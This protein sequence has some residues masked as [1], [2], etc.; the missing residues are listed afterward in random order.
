MELDTLNSRLLAELDNN[1]RQS[2]SKIAKKLRVGKNVINYRINNLEKAGIIQGYYTVIDAYRLGYSAY[3]IYLK[4][5]YTSPRKE[6]EIV[7]YLVKLPQTRWVVFIKGKFNIGAVFLVRNQAELVD[8]WSK[9][10]KKYHEYIYEPQICISY[11]L[12]RYRLPFAKEYL[13]ERANTDLVQIGGRVNIDSK[14]VELL[15]LISGNGRIPLLEIATKL[16]LTPTTVQYRLRQLMKKRIILGFR[17]ILN[18][19]KLGY[20]LYKIDF[21]LRNSEAYEKIK[22]FAQEH[23]DIFCLVKT[24]GWADVELEVYAKNTQKFYEI[25]EDIR[26]RFDGVIR[27][28]NFF[29]YSKIIKF[30]YTPF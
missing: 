25:V 12:E 15:R 9:F 16:R 8:L 2:N 14:D 19:E 28:Y 29:M 13:K 26:K 30:R 27:D 24:V 4:L 3:R 20:T 10:D 11:G 21:N 18:M 1:A 6:A 5:Q 23:G 17:P 7:D 22:N